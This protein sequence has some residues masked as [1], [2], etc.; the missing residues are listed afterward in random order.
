MEH[1]ISAIESRN[2]QVALD[3]AW[4]RSFTRRL[5]IAAITYATTS[6]LF[7]WVIPQDNWYIAAFVPTTGYILST[8]SLPWLKKSWQ[9]RYRQH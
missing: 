1:R 6:C 7:I 4:E 3:K 8:L 9:S 5:T 2:Q